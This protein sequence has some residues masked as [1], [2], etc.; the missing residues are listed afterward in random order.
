MDNATPVTI[1][2]QAKRPSEIIA[3]LVEIAGSEAAI[4]EMTRRKEEKR[5]KE[6]RS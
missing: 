1:P 2:I 3:Q 5:T 4:K 6:K